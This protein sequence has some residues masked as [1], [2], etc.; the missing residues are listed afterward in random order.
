M[1]SLSI[2]DVAQRSGLAPSAL[3]YYET[4][5]L[6]SARRDHRGQ[7]R[8]PRAVLRRLG[9][10]RLGRSLGLSLEQIQAELSGLPPHRAPTR[11]EWRETSLRWDSLLRDQIDSLAKTRRS[12]AEC[13]ECGCL[14]PATCSLL[15]A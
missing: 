3:R 1:S 14:R 4:L 13:T 7:R 2:T 15:D 6:I 11:A 10:I 5:A 8:Y 9:L 12:L